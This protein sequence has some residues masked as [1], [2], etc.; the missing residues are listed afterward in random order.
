MKPTISKKVIIASVVGCGLC[1]LPFILPIAAGIAG[2]S[3]FSFSIG[4]IICGTIL[5]ALA[6]FLLRIYIIKRKNNMCEMPNNR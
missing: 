5:V 1:C 6:A 4:E 2:F 3:I